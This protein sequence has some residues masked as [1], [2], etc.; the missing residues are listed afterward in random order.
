[1][2]GRLGSIVTGHVLVVC[3]GMS[4]G[5]H[6]DSASDSA[7]H[8]QMHVGVCEELE[9]HTSHLQHHVPA[10]A[11]RGVA[12]RRVEVVVRHACGAEL[13]VVGEAVRDPVGV[14]IEGVEAGQDRPHETLIV[15]VAHVDDR[16]AAGELLRGGD[17]RR[18]V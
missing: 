9:T 1:M 17:V 18:P 12:V 13:L 7:F 16:L 4:P 14:A 2:C 8:K 11:R 6:R 15:L 3:H 10:E 5:D